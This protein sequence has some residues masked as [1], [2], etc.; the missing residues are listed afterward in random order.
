MAKVEHHRITERK[1]E[2]L[3]WANRASMLDEDGRDEAYSRYVDLSEPYFEKVAENGG[4]PW[5]SS[6]IERRELYDRRYQRPAAPEGLFIPEIKLK[7]A[8]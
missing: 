3:Y 5:W 6:D 1:P 2:W 8:P 4:T 7:K